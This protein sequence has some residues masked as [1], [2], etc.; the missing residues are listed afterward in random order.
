MH[1][2]TSVASLMF[3]TGNRT[4]DLSV[5][6]TVP[7]PLS[8]TSRGENGYFESDSNSFPQS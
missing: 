3:L 7:N 6:R 4:G 1:E 2:K 5:H 8:Q